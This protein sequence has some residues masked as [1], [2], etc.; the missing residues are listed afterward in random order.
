MIPELSNHF[1]ASRGMVF[2]DCSCYQTEET[3]SIRSKLGRQWLATKDYSKTILDFYNTLIGPRSKKEVRDK[4]NSS[5]KK[6]DP[7]FAFKLYK[8][9]QDVPPPPVD[10]NIPCLIFEAEHFTACNENHSFI[11]QYPNGERLLMQDDY[12]FFFF[13]RPYDFNKKIHEFISRNI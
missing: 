13:E 4:V 5:L 2:V 1:K 6:C 12:H 3:K 9:Y 8:S 7:E 10:E 11:Q